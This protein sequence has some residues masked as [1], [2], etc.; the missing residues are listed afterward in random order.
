[1]PS[2]SLQLQK[3][4]QA[5]QTGPAKLSS[6]ERIAHDLL[7]KPTSSETYQPKNRSDTHVG[8]VIHGT[9]VNNHNEEIDVPVI[10]FEILKADPSGEPSSTDLKVALLALN[11]FVTMH[12]HLKKEQFEKQMQNLEGQSFRFFGES[13]KESLL[14][15]PNKYLK[16]FKTPKNVDRMHFM[17]PDPLQPGYFPYMHTKQSE[18]F[19]NEHPIDEFKKK[20]IDALANALFERPKEKPDVSIELEEQSGQ[21]SEEFVDIDGF[22]N[23]E[24]AQQAAILEQQKA[25]AAAIDQIPDLVSGLADAHMAAAP[26]TK[27]DKDGNTVIN[28]STGQELLRNMANSDPGHFRDILREQNLDQDHA[29]L[30]L[31]DNTK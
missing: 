13:N 17:A 31:I 24:E 4:D 14:D 20:D 29:L 11:S 2:V 23:A 3:K 25:Q 8:F 26:T 5:G 1:M 7:I 27:Q 18:R 15:K 28:F 19:L 16:A 10:A 21:S 22:R 6:A 9:F 30:D 12:K